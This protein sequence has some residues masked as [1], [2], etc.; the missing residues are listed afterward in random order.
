MAH[1][2]LGGW[3]P[4]LLLNRWLQLVLITP[5]MFYTGAPV[6]RTGWLTLRHRTADMNSLIT[7]G[8]VAAYGYSPR[9]PPH[10]KF[11][12]DPVTQ[13]G[14][15]GSAVALVAQLP[16]GERRRRCRG[17]GGGPGGWVDRV[18]GTGVAGGCGDCGGER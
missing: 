17:R 3:V 13:V 10:T 1:D 15:G 6:H 18:P 12:T 11:L 8:T 2:V 5:V 4:G 7:L 14:N 16:P 9:R